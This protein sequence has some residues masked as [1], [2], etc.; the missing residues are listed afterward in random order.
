M[1][2]QYA[3]AADPV[4][5]LISP[6]YADLSGLPPLQ[7]H[8]AAH[9]IMRSDADRLARQARAAE[10]QCELRLWPTS[11]LAGS[12]SAMLGAAAA[13]TRSHLTTAPEG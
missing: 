1:A 6:V 12:A 3:A 11:A 2:R 9:G 8:V 10:V 7:V 13:F 4:H 5:P